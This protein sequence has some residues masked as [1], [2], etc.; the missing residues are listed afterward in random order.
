MTSVLM[1][2]VRADWG[3]G[4]EHIYRLIEHFP[5]NILPYIACPHDYPYWDRY[6]KILGQ[7]K[8]VEIPHRRFEVSSLLKAKRFIKQN[9]I[10]LIHSHGKGAGLYSR[11][12]SLM[13]N[14][15][16]VHT[17]HG[18]HLGEYGLVKTKAYLLLERLLSKVSSGLISVSDGEASQINSL[19]ICP[20]KKLY[21]V[22]NGVRIPDDY[23]MGQY[24]H[25]GK[26]FIIHT[27]RFDYPKNFDLL[28][29][30]WR[31]LETKKLTDKLKLII[32]GQGQ[33]KSHYENEVVKNNWQEQIHFTGAIENT[34]E[35][36]S[37]ALCYLSTSRW[38]GM[39]L[40][41]LEAMAMA[42]PVIATDV[43]GNR[44]VVDSGVTGLLFDLRKPQEAADHIAELLDSNNCKWQALSEASRHKAH[45]SYSAEQMALNTKEVYRKVLAVCGK[46]IR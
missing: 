1:I 29:D 39:P 28:L 10:Q 26:Y 22:P 41:V 11:L 19:S 16:C 44:D 3:G 21:V 12:L 17:F 31:S 9:N 5:A 45:K 20:N 6:R 7:N 24:M 2:S 8:M 30:I 25:D 34:Q 43:V 18:I 4:P 42:V 36:L 38:E 33:M 27:T 14:T 46:T 23:N 35:Y 40:A 13:T 32:I 15:P 37:K